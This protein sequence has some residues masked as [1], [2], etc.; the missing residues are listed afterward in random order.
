MSDKYEAPFTSRKSQDLDG[1]TI[2]LIKDKQLR[3]VGYIWDRRLATLV[4]AVLN[5]LQ[6]TK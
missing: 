1:D 3:E 4:V 6:R 5:C 2:Y